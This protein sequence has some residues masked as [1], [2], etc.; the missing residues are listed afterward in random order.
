M[1][2]NEGASWPPAGQQ[3]VSSVDAIGEL[4]VAAHGDQ[5]AVLVNEVAST[6]VS[7]G[8]VAVGRGTGANGLLAQLPSAETYCLPVAATGSSV[9]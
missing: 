1:S 6:A 4:H 3:E 5:F 8:A 9:A 2:T 7:S